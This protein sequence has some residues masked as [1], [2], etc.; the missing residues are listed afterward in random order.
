MPHL[1]HFTE[2]Q[3]DE[4]RKT[5]ADVT[6]SYRIRY[7]FVIGGF[8]LFGTFGL[9]GYKHVQDQTVHE[10]CVVSHQLVIGIILRSVDATYADYQKN[11]QS[12]LDKYKVVLKGN[13]TYK[14]NP[15]LLQQNL[16]K[17]AKVLNDS[18]PALC[19]N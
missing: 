15:K 13:P 2:E 17:T 5:I 10:S 16:E 6:R 7:W 18:D 1:K 12:V 3:A 11:P 14:N 8:V 4:I 9:Y 19:P